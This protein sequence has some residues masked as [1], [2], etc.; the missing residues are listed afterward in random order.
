MMANS[1]GSDIDGGFSRASSRRGSAVERM[2]ITSRRSQQTFNADDFSDDD[3]D[4]VGDIRT[5]LERAD[6]AGDR[7]KSVRLAIQAAAQLVKER[8]P[9]EALKVLTTHSGTFVAPETKR[10]VLRIAN[11]LFSFDNPQRNVNHIWKSLRDSLYQLSLSASDE[12]ERQTV[13]K[14]LM[15]THYIMLKNIFASLENQSSAKE[16][17]LKVTVALLRYT[18][19]VRVDKGFYEAGLLAKNAEKLE[20]AFVFW[21]HFLDLI[22]A[23]EE[24][25]VCVYTTSISLH[26]NNSTLA[27][28]RPF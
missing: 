4:E 13:E 14:A 26:L 16:L 6:K 25:E 15:V 17:E 20:M 9:V 8:S 5:Q 21:N 18:D 10:I 28:Y 23:I 3:N 2:S 11:D 7:E 12:N 19:L 1:R 27:E 24:G 22:E